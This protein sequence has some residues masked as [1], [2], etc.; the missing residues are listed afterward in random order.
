MIKR[1]VEVEIG[2]MAGLFSRDKAHYLMEET[3]LGPAPTL[4]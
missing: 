1:E 2:I 4:G 3:K